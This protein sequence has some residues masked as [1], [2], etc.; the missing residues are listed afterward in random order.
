MSGYTHDLMTNGT[1]LFQI[2]VFY[3]SHVSQESFEHICGGDRHVIGR[4]NAD[5]NLCVPILKQVTSA[6]WKLATSSEYR[7][8]RYIFREGLSTVFRTSAMQSS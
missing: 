4:R 7:T 2:S 5:Y 3:N 8:I 1:Q 6:I